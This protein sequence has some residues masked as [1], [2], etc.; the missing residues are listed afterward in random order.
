MYKTE[1]KT[2]LQ[3]KIDPPEKQTEINGE[4]DTF[5]KFHL[6][7]LTKSGM[8]RIKGQQRS[9]LFLEKLIESLDETRWRKLEYQEKRFLERDIFLHRGR[10]LE[11]L[12][13]SYESKRKEKFNI[14]I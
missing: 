10:K 2:K 9:F 14:P 11:T 5:Q 8:S 6:G 13:H 7:E 1:Q 12:M 4:G 3:K